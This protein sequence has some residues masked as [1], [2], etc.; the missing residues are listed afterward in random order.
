[1]GAQGDKN[2]LLPQI[3]VLLVT[4]AAAALIFAIYHLVAATCCRRRLGQPPQHRPIIVFRPREF[5]SSIESSMAQLIP[6]HKYQKGTGPVGEDCTCPVCLCEFEDGDEVRTL[7]ECM[8]SY[9][10]PCIDMWLYSHSSCP[11]CR[12][13]ATSSPFIF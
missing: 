2:N 11:M 5:P 6:A 1:M 9:H 8:H 10:V 13:D 12:S 7:Q 3:Y 4:V